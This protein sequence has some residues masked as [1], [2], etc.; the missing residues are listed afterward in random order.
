MLYNGITINL[1]VRLE[2]HLAG[3]GSVLVSRYKVFDLVYFE[4]HDKPDDA[5]TREKQIKGWRREKKLTLILQS[6][7]KM[8][9]LK[10]QLI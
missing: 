10:S 7:P 9:D 4:A 2:M 5:I 1:P 3:T 6:N 8:S